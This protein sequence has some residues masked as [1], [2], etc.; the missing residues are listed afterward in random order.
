MNFKKT[1]GAL[2]C[3][4]LTAVAS[5]MALADST[6]WYGGASVGPTRANIDNERISNSLLGNGF[7][8]VAIDE[9]GRSTGYKIFGGYQFNRNF[10]LEGGYFD[11]GKFGFNA[12]T[13][14]AGRLQGDIK[15]R[16]LNLDL[17]GTLPLTDKF[18]ALARVGAN[19]ARASDRFSGTGAVAVNDPNPRKRDTN[20]KLGLG[21]QY[22]FSDSLAMRAE[23]ERYRVNDAVGNKGDVDMVSVGL[24]YRF[25]GPV[26]APVAR[27]AM[28][29]P[30]APAPQP[31]VVATPAPMSLP[32]PAPPPPPP[33]KVTI[34]ADSLFAFDKATVTPAGRQALDAFAAD[35]KNLQFD[36][37]M[38]T[39]HSDRIGSHAYNMKL[40][41]RRAEAVSAYLV[42]S[43]GIPAA[44]MLSKGVDGADPVTKP[45]DCK[46]SKVSKALIA[47]LQPD[48]RVELEVVGTR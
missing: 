21:V 26:S 44:K 17:V 37:I 40:S 35:V 19:Y 33:M 16:G 43:A 34:A 41:T 38:V 24:V 32:T 14:P 5:P 31:Q 45:G 3:A 18:S 22:A 15:L 7:S 9:D 28:P 29:E 8:A 25:G 42:Q 11:L 13:V 46:G 10:A 1:S 48:R 27:A 4:A 30:V 6:G 39:G 23:V 47:C 20:L 12:T 36:T 2:A